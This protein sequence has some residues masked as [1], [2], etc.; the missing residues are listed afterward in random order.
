VA[1]GA[2]ALIAS[3][4]NDCHDSW[5]LRRRRKGGEGKTA[6]AA[7]CTRAPAKVLVPLRTL[8]AAYHPGV[9]GLRRRVMRYQAGRRVPSVALRS[10]RRGGPAENATHRIVV[11]PAPAD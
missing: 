2:R 8:A 11:A 6:F 9:A 1:A 7:N 3:L 5:A 10:P 4:C